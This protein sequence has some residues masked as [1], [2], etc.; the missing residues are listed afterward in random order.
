[1]LELFKKL[2]QI[3]PEAYALGDISVKPFKNILVCG[4]GGS[5][6][7]GYLLKDL[8]D[9]PVEIAQSYTIPKYVSKDTLAFIISYSGN[10][11]ETINMLRRTR[12]KTK[13]IVLI[14]SDGK[15]AK[16]KE[17]KVLVPTGMQPRD[18]IPYLF[19]PMWFI[20]KQKGI[21]EVISA[22]KQINIKE[23]KSLA[24]KIKN[25][26]P[27]VY[28]SYQHKAIAMRWKT[29]FNED[30]KILAI[31]NVYPEMDHNEIESDFKKVFTI[32]LRDQKDHPEIRKEMDLTQRRMHAHNILLKGK[33]RLAKTFYGIYFG[34][35][36]AYYLALLLKKDPYRYEFIEKLKAKLK[37]G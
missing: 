18:A 1:M 25:K 28:A 15:L 36:T 37:N 20:L 34:D 31:S 8:I 14:T 7:P 2:P 3:I 16:E 33:S 30:A 23:A 6:F 35:L 10:T 9:T 13:N 11:E 27:A 12:K 22:V 19:F 4:M 24:A 32:L 26:I 29:Q 17:K 21:P 5:G